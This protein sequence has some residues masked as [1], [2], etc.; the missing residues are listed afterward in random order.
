[1]MIDEQYLKTVWLVDDDRSIR[2]SLSLSLSKRGYQIHAFESA[3]HY[4]DEAPYTAP[5]CL[6][7]DLSMPGMDGL[8]LQEELNTRNAHVPIIFLTAHGS[9]PES[10]L[11]MKNGA[12]DFLE[13][14]FVQVALLQ[15]IDA[16][17]ILDRRMR[18]GLNEIK[19]IQLRFSSLSIRE[20]EVM[21]LLVSDPAGLSTKAIAD[22]LA[23][24]PRT[25]EHHRAKLMKKTGARSP[26]ELVRMVESMT[27]MSNIAAAETIGSK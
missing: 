8:E 2:K 21:Q 27:G 16:A 20:T 26:A 14:P 6:L 5:G 9:V 19:A 15:K 25:I 12:L 4:L 23:L 1:M 3:E 17:L 13:K 24:S 11:A 10:V 22:A 18:E 7:L